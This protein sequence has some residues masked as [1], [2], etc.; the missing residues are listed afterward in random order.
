MSSSSSDQPW[1]TSHCGLVGFEASSGYHRLAGT[2][3]WDVQPIPG[4]GAP[5]GPP[6]GQVRIVFHER[7]E[8]PYIVVVTP[9]RTTSAPH[10]GANYG[11]VDEEGFRV[12]LFDAF[13]A[14]TLQNGPFSFVVLSAP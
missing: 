6:L 13:M 1:V 9:G 3:N 12:H 14:R 8:M 4:F 10:L 11:D 7:L 2:T 5:I